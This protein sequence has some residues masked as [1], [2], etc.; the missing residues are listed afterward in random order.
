MSRQTKRD[1]TVDGYRPTTEQLLQYSRRDFL[2]LSG[3]AAAGAFGYLS[4]PGIGIVPRAWGAPPPE[5]V[6]RAHCGSMQDWGFSDPNFYDAVKQPVYDDMFARGICTLTGKTNILDAWTN[7]LVGYEPGHKIVI[8]LNLNSYDYNANQT[9][10]MAY[11]VIES[12]KHFGVSA[13]DIKVFDAVRRIPDYWRNRWD[14][15]VD[16]VNDQNADWDDNATIYFPHIDTS[17]RIPRILS[18]ADH[19]INVCLQKGHKS[20][21]TGSMKNHFGSQEDPSDLHVSRYENIATLANSG[22]ILGKTRLIAVEAAYMTW[23]H[24]GHPF[25]ETQ[26]TDL[27]P[28]GLSGH[29]SPNFMLFGT[30][31]VTMD[32]VLGDIQNHERAARGEFVW[33]NEFIDIAAGAPYNL[34]TRDQ[35]EFVPNAA[36]WSQVDLSYNQFDYVSFDLPLADRQQIDA[37]NLRLRSGEIHWS[38]LQ[39]LVERYTDR[40]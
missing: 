21:V 20:Y 4:L 31:M 7:L 40:L 18:Q 2:K 22:H 25:E 36:G 37:L 39:N 17:H 35:A 15:D 11:T 5:R 26:A 16:Y 28:A 3:L 13:G 19:L 12:L 1:K 23:H 10:E 14:S 8:K 27:F 30:N 24:E 6:V 32:S 34:G 29:S 33:E 9:C 38:Q